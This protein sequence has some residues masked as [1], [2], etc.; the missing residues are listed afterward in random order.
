ME[1]GKV[2]IKANFMSLRYKLLTERR[3]DDDII[4][5]GETMKTIHHLKICI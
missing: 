3:T 4:I 5:F 2:E 1:L